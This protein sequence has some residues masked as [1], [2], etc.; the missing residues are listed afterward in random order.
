MEG[1]YC[2]NME[3]RLKI[4]D[5]LL[6]FNVFSIFYTCEPPKSSKMDNHWM[7]YVFLMDKKTPVLGCSEYG[8]KISRK[9]PKSKEQGG[10]QNVKAS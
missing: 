5:Q 10:N 8:A 9:H 7:K 2:E 3:N 1:Y 6:I 4:K